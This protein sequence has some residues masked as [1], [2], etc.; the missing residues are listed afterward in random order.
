M[1]DDL[2]VVISP[3]GGFLPWLRQRDRT[4]LALLPIVPAAGSRLRRLKELAE[5][6]DDSEDA[7]DFT[8]ALGLVARR[9]GPA[10]ARLPASTRSSPATSP[11][12]AAW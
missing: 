2:A 3:A 4:G 6:A 11:G 10:A 8:G 7:G 12:W 5:A 9:G 1:A